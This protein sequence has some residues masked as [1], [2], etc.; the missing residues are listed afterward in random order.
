[1]SY[2]HSVVVVTRGGPVTDS[3][4][5]G[6]GPGAV[7]CPDITHTQAPGLRP[8][9]FAQRHRVRSELVP[10]KQPV[11]DKQDTVF[12]NQVEKKSHTSLHSRS[13]VGAFQTLE[14]V[15]DRSARATLRAEQRNIHMPIVDNLGAPGL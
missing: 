14:R 5:A 1:M 11:S 4:R 3:Q 12:K 9:T 13:E 2:V 7:Q 8:L 6:C 10:V 15:K